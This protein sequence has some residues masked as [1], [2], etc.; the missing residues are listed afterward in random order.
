MYIYIYGELFWFQGPI[1]SL[2]LDIPSISVP[3]E[4]E[5]RKNLSLY[6]ALS[7]KGRAGIEAAVGSSEALQGGWK[8]LKIPNITW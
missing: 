5:L 4:T 1:T 6:P 8:A 3:Q 7:V 2:M